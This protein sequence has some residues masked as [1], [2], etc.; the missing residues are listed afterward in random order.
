MKFLKLS[1]M[2]LLTVFVGTSFVVQAKVNGCSGWLDKGSCERYKSCQWRKDQRGHDKCEE[3]PKKPNV[4]ATPAVPATP[5]APAVPAVAVL[6]N[7]LS[8]PMNVVFY[9]ADPANG[10]TVVAATGL[11]IVNGNSQIGGNPEDTNYY[12]SVPAGATSVVVGPDNEDT[13]S[14]GTVTFDGLVVGNTYQIDGQGA[15]GTLEVIVAPAS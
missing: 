1:V 6:N 5:T 10:G 12:V 4:K 7:Q 11:T 13:N 15:G 14:T 9:T 3:K 8:N 2:A